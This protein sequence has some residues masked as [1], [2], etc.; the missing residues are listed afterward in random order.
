[1]PIEE[2]TEL[3]DKNGRPTTQAIDRL[4]N[5][6]FQKAYGSDSL[7]DLYAQAADP[8][9]K[10]I[11][12]ALARVAPRMAQLEGAGEYDVRNA[13]IQAAELAVNAR[14]S[15]MNLKTA[16]QQIGL[17]VDPNSALVLDMFADN[18]R[19]SKRIA[20]RLGALADEAYKQT[21]AVPDMF[22]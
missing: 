18:V 17:D 19:S 2:R 22:G 9:A 15:G 13:V 11:L 14:R 8:E 21:Q 20:D 1:M 12:N 16:A 5:A 6:I 7:I 10:T 3:T 4:A